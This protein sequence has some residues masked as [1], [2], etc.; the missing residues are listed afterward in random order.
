M[1]VTLYGKNNMN[2]PK[3][4]SKKYRGKG[5]PPPD[6]LLDLHSNRYF[7]DDMNYSTKELCEILGKQRDTIRRVI[8]LAYNKIYDTSFPIEQRIVNSLTTTFYSGKILRKLSKDY[9]DSYI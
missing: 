9:S 5:R 4:I 1:L 2:S 3:I 8:E 6:W 7:R